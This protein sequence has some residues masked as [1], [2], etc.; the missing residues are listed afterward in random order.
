MVLSDQYIAGFF[1]G[2]GTA[3]L[4]KQN[5][6]GVPYPKAQVMLSQS[7]VNGFD[8]LTQIQSQHGGK[9]YE[10]LKPGQYKATKSAYKLYW[11][12]EEAIV[13]LKAILPHLVLKQQEA[14]NVLEHMT[15]KDAK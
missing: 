8:L 5:K 10:H 14:I 7:G 9:I 6:K 13:F 1:D 11:N 15:R 4:G 3:Y 12:R 2:E